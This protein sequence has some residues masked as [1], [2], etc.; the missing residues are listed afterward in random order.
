MG[1]CCDDGW[2]EEDTS[3]GEEEEDDEDQESSDNDGLHGRDLSR[4]RDGYSCAASKIKRLTILVAQATPI[5]ASSTQQEAIDTKRKE[6]KVKGK[7]KGKGRG[8][9]SGASWAPSEAIK[10]MVGVGV[11]KGRSGE[12]R[13]ATRRAREDV[14][15]DPSKEKRKETHSYDEENSPD[16]DTAQGSKTTTVVNGGMYFGGSKDVNLALGG[17]G[18]DVDDFFTGGS[19]FGPGVEAPPGFVLGG[20]GGG[21]GNKV[22]TFLTTRSGVNPGGDAAGLVPV[23]VERDGGEDEDAHEEAGG[24]DDD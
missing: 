10:N 16:P 7:G 11:G 9:K 21:D 1:V 4:P 23:V 15:V 6:G 19:G 14:A 2:A 8:L 13:K 24:E 5:Q 12:A 20:V 22:F 17:H 3:D 18:F